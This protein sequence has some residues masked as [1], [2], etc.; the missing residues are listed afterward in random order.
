MKNIYLV[1]HA[2]AEPQD[3]NIS[4]FD[5]KLIDIGIL[6]SKKVFEKLKSKNPKIDLVISSSAI[7]TIMTTEIFIKTFK[8]DKKNVMYKKEL[9][10]SEI[11]DIFE[12]F[13]EI[14]NNVNNI[15]LVGHNPAIT[16]LAKL[17]S[18]NAS[19]IMKTSDLVSVKILTENWID[20]NKSNTSFDFD[21]I[22]KEI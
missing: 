22:A 15:L 2:K 17:Y 19:I 20:V 12:I 6:R 10:N 21:I 16:N 18:N 4:D 8:Y 9:Y 13:K 14:N 3:Y 11:E 7:R 1:R 5:R